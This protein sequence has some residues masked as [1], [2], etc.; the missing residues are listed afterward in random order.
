MSDRSRS[1]PRVGHRAALLADARAVAGDAG[2]A[3]GFAAEHGGSLPRPGRGATARRW[4]MLADIAAADLTAARV[5][6][7]HTDALAIL[8]EAGEAA[9][10]G[11]WGVFAAEGPGVRV[12]ARSAADGTLRLEGTKPWCSLAGSLDHA[13]VT[14]HIG[15]GRGLYAVDLHHRSVR[16]EP[17]DGWVARGLSQVPSCPVHFD[18]T[19]AVPVGPPGWYLSRPGFAW[20]GIGVAACWLGG[21]RPLAERLRAD[22][23]R[24]TDGPEAAI[25]AMTLGAVDVALHAASGCLADAAEQVDSGRA[26]GRAGELLMLRARA[27]IA[28]AVEETIERVGHALGPA[29]LAFDA[30]YARRVADLQLYVRQ[31]HAERDLAALGRLLTEM[32]P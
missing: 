5:F 21:A 12:D 1:L 20:G 6:E 2:V 30:E 24:R 3:L 26:R 23:A 32:A 29:P 7:A 31:H 4:Q 18:A 11:T 25:H 13:L 9:P 16:V 8:D 27:V 15:G 22:T 17:P 28:R 14:A 19:P 10:G